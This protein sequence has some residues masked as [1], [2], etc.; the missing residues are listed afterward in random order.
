MD[1]VLGGDFNGKRGGTGQFGG[2]LFRE[3]RPVGSFTDYHP[4]CARIFDFDHIDEVS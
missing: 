3:I 2:S 1:G 4:S